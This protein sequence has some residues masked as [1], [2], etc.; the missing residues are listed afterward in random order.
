MEVPEREARLSLYLTKGP[1]THANFVALKL[2]QVSS[3]FKTAAISRRQ[4]ALKI[5]PGLHVRF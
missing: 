5:A 3:M 2:Q 4:I 1:F